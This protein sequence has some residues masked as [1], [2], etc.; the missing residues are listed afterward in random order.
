MYWQEKYDKL[1]ATGEEK[2]LRMD[3]LKSSYE[4]VIEHNLEEK[5]GEHTYTLEINEFSDL[6]CAHVRQTV[7][8]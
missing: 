1:Y 4:K 8:A 6:V 5:R 3:I 7:A 2:N